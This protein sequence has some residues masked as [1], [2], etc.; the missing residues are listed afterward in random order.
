[1]FGIRVSD[2]AGKSAII[3]SKIGKIIA[4]GTITMSNSLNDDDTYGTDIDL[5]GVTGIPLEDIAVLTY[6]VKFTYDINRMWFYQSKDSFVSWY[7][8]HYAESTY[9]YYT[10]HP[11]T[12]VM[13]IWTAGNMTVGTQST[14]DAICTVFP[15]SGWDFVGTPATFTKVRIWA[16]TAYI[17]YDY[18]ASTFKTVF[19]IGDKGVE[20]VTY[21][22]FLKNN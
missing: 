1:M 3:T 12:G 15:L 8:S 14:W 21:M 22:V 19:S 20:K 17:V 9:T 4:T 11:T 16:A 10:K 5:P 18:S 7:C 13:S 6:P 2:D